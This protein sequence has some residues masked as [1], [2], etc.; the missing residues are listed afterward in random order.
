MRASLGHLSNRYG[1]TELGFSFH[2]RE[3]TTPD[4]RWSLDHLGLLLS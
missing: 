1:Q 3:P 4:L 2:W